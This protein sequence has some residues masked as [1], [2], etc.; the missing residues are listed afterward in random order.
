[1]TANQLYK[2]SGSKKPFKQWLRDQQRLGHLEDRQAANFY[3]A[4]SDQIDQ[5]TI[6]QYLILGGVVFLAYYLW[7][8]RK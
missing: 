3:N 5:P 8:R 2:K 1:M 4:A 7:T 6:A